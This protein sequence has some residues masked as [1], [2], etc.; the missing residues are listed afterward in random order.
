MDMVSKGRHANGKKTNC[1]SC[2]SAYSEENTYYRKDGSR[3]C[4]QC[5]QA[6]NRK[7][8]WRNREK[9]TEHKR[10]LYHRNKALAAQSQLN[11]NEGEQC[12]H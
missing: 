12:P 5:Y 10:A 8:H 3:S 6:Q 7:Y 4:K 2:G 1:G 9:I 11:L